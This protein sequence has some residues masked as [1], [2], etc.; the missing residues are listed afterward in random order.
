[1]RSSSSA[2]CQ[3]HHRGGT[4][5]RLF[6][7]IAEVVSPSVPTV[8]ESV[9]IT[10]VMTRDV[11]CVHRNLEIE[12]VTDLI[13]QNFIG[14]LVVVDR[15]HRPVGMITNRDVVVHL[16]CLLGSKTS[17]SDEGPLS[18]DL[19]PRTAEEIMLPL[20]LTL[21]ATATLAQAAALMAHEGFHHVPVVAD[22][23]VVGIVSALDIVRW[24]A[25]ND[26]R[27]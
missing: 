24:L 17:D 8:A 18:D 16:G 10:A 12:H 25:R 3:I 20:A 19:S 11:I 26:A 6:T 14:C 9:P 7:E 22:G 5:E 15:A 1:M 23:R 27:A 21:P 13:V 2:G 4:I